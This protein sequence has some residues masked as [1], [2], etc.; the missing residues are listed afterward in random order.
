MLR[1]YSL[2]EAGRKVWDSQSG[3]VSLDH[4]KLLGLVGIDSDP[5]DLSV[6]LGWSDS[7]TNEILR[8]LEEGGL[9]KSVGAALSQDDLDF[10]GSFRVEDFEA[11]ARAQMRKD[12]DF[13]GPLSEEALR[14][15]REKK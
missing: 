14:A 9:V 6:K 5:R 12:L 7:E 3:R 4:R 8:E 2:T 13:T 11:A 1:L 15:A 10:T